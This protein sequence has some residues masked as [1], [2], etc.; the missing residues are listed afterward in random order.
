MLFLVHVRHDVNIDLIV[1][2]LRND[3]VIFISAQ[4]EKGANKL[5]K[6]FFHS[7]V[8]H[9]NKK[10]TDIFHEPTELSCTFTEYYDS[11]INIIF[12]FSVFH[13]EY[14]IYNK[15]RVVKYTEED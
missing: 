10:L 7:K 4:S 15:L 8:I 3:D 5:L 14:D 9:N 12:N 11:Y 1:G 2:K 6:E 13:I